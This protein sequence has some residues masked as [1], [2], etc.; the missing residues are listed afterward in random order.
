MT[1]PGLG[2]GLDAR[3]AER[4]SGRGLQEF[5][6]G[7]SGESPIWGEEERRMGGSG[8][9]PLAFGGLLLGMGALV[10]SSLE[11]LGVEAPPEHFL[12]QG[13]AECHFFNGTQRIRYLERHFFDRQELCYFDSDRGKFVAVA[14]LAESQAK[15][16][17][18]DKAFLQSRKAAV[19]SFCR[20]NYGILDTFSQ[21]LRVQPQ[22]KITPTDNDESSPHNTLL[23]CTVNRFF[24]AGIEIKWF[25]NG[26]EEP[27]VWTTDL[28]R[29]GDWT[30]HIEVMLETKPERGDVYTCQVEHASFEGPVTVKWEPQSD[31]ARSKMWTGIV[32]IVLGLVFGATGL[33]LYLKNK[34]G[35]IS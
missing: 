26:K 34:K 20:Y 7:L 5:P 16:W 19:D 4:W 30:F 23:I 14:E 35:L 3:G 1:L 18:Q 12:F 28:I 27:K 33:A 17:N 13:K 10:V 31:S 6:P 22:V 29:N 24:P 32:G 11:G 8:A 15:I 9:A 25:R 21:S 2:G